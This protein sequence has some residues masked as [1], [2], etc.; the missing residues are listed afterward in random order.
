[1][2]LDAFDWV[3]PM[4]QPHND[5]CTIVLARLRADLQFPG[6][7]LFGDDQRVVTSGRHGTWNVSKNRLA[8]MFNLADLA[9]HD[10]FGTDDIAA[11]GRPDCL[12][13]KADTK[14][15]D[16][17]HKVFDQINADSGFLRR[18][19]SGRD[20]DMIGL[21]LFDFF[22]SDLVIAAHLDLLPQFAQVLHQVVSERIVVVE[23]VDHAT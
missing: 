3:A 21:S 13:P 17:P 20:Q 11:K 9:M 23:D 1:M 16:L 4:A 22:R 7:P 10:L 14:N 19:R 12:M 2:K 6:K 18:T 5:A 8:V 15:R